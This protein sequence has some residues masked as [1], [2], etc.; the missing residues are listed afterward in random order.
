MAVIV[1]F[2][3]GDTGN[4]Q[5]GHRGGVAKFRGGKTVVSDATLQEWLDEGFPVEKVGDVDP[6]DQ[7]VTNYFAYHGPSQ[8]AAMEKEMLS[9]QN[10]GDFPGLGSYHEEDELLGRFARNHGDTSVNVVNT[11]SSLDKAV[12]PQ[13]RLSPN[14]IPLVEMTDSERERSKQIRSAAKKIR[15]RYGVPT[16]ETNAL[17]HD[18]KLTTDLH[19]G[20]DPETHT[21]ERALKADVETKTATDELNAPAVA[22]TSAKER[23]SEKTSK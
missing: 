11:D 15:E 17:H 10:V 13:N 7:T 4:H 16:D 12:D 19:D 3:G 22:E 18:F 2:K 14:R 5:L 8:V 23:K 21:D 20:L 1:Q 6:S 9:K